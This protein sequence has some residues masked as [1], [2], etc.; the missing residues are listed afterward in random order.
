MVASSNNVLFIKRYTI[1]IADGVNI[2]EL[3]LLY[4]LYIDID[5][6]KSP[7]QLTVFGH[8]LLNPTE[9]IVYFPEF[10]LN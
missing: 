10:R 9:S 5:K 1:F 6:G 4:I 7:Y 2:I 3:T 8:L